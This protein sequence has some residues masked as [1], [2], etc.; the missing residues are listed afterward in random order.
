M[1]PHLRQVA[2]D[3]EVI[4]DSIA[5]ATDALEDARRRGDVRFQESMLGYL[6][7][8]HRV[9]GELD[10]AESYARQALALQDEAR[11]ATRVASLIRLGEVLRC[12]HRFQEAIEAHRRALSEIRDP[13]TERYRSFALQHLGKVF[14]NMGRFAEAE[15]TLTEALEIRRQAGEPGLIASTEEALAYARERRGA[16]APDETM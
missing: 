15:S 2:T 5:M 11:A 10:L 13:E 8:A 6:A 14:L 1:D 12:R 3:E 9:I 7:E 16:V 4:R